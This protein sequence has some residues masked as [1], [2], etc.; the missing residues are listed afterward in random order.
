[1]A[2]P[3]LL[4]ADEPTSGLDGQSA[5]TIVSFL[6][7]LADAGQSVLVTVHQP[8]ASLFA[9]FDS[10]LLLKAGGKTVYF[11][12]TA[13]MP[14]YFADNG[15]AFPR[16]VN[17]AEYMIDIVSGDLSRER[18]W[19]EVWLK[20]KQHQFVVEELE[21]LKEVNRDV[22]S[23]NDDDKFGEWQS[24]NWLDIEFIGRQ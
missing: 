9:V 11:G 15:I 8:S 16:D 19:A 3:R 17:P 23:T 21:R 14:E 13:T 18:D 6:R 1:M 22:V 10:L 20:S 2:K 4:F 5:F 24:T 12:E 7:K